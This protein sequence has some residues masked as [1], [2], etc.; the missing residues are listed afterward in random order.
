MKNFFYF[1]STHP[2]L[3]HQLAALGQLVLAFFLGGVLGLQRERHGKAAGTR[4]YA[5]VSAGAALFTVCVTLA[6]SSATETARMTSQIIT[7]IGFIGAGTILR[8]DDR[9]EG[10]TTAAGLW[11]AAGIGV[12]VGLGLYYLAVGAATLTLLVLSIDDDRIPFSQKTTLKEKP[13]NKKLAT[14]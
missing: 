13:R 7:G 14:D 9:I 4:T 2:Q 10:I 1:I 8:R 6:F 3:F 12:T 11:F 5:L